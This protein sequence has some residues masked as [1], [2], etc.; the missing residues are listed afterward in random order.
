MYVYSSE[1]TIPYDFEYGGDAALFEGESIQFVTAKLED[2]SSLPDTKEDAVK[3]FTESDNVSAFVEH[4][5]TGNRGTTDFNFTPNESGLWMVGVVTVD[6]GNGF[7][8]SNNGNLSIDGNVTFVGIDAFSVHEQKS[9][10]TTPAV[11]HP[12][13]NATI[14]VDASALSAGNKNVSHAVAVFN[15]DRLSNFDYTVNA[16]NR[17]NITIK[18]PIEQVTG[19]ASTPANANI[20]GVKPQKR[21]FTGTKTVLS[22][23][24]R[25][26]N[27]T[28]ASD[29]VSIRTGD[30]TIYASTVARVTD[31]KTSIDVPIP[32][33]AP[34]DKYVVMHVAT[35]EG[36]TETV[37]NRKELSVTQ[38]A[39]S[40]TI[41]AGSSSISPTRVKPDETFNVSVDVENTGTAT[42]TFAKPLKANGTAIATDRVTLDAGESDTLTYSTSIDT[43]GNYTLTVDGV[44]LGTITVKT[45]TTGGGG[46][47]GDD[48]TP[49]DAYE[50]DRLFYEDKFDAPL[51]GGESVSA[52]NITFSNKTT[53][54]VI[55]QERTNVPGTVGEPDG[56]AVGYVKITVPKSAR[57]DPST[58]KFSVR[59]SKLD[60][61]DLSASDLEVQ[62]FNDDTG[63]W[64]SIDTR[65]VNDGDDT[66]VL[67]ADTPGFSYFAITADEEPTT[68]TEPPTD[69]PTTTTEPPTDGPTTTT[70]PPTD[71][72]TTTGTGVPGF[73]AVLAVIALLAIALVAVRRD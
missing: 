37:S 17:S 26:N 38:D 46:G 54:E 8:G 27:S 4:E 39:P 62:R 23:F 16:T 32:D 58:L 60:E 42:G 66:V 20:M 59:Q 6:D 52:V 14:E 68:T 61:L 45:P 53:G 35:K 7:S 21:S 10:I 9:H 28:S 55:V 34:N 2:G 73:G 31:S 51:K 41:D 24:A 67:E 29:N 11:A 65:V 36:S 12:G 50:R 1:K 13:K 30:K 18:T 5:T 56:V 3:R 44:T 72:P 47:G 57:D 63:D 64:E 49:N 48:D 22:L 33:G 15:E 43:D 71:G 25:L 70:E 19:T 69:G 40:F